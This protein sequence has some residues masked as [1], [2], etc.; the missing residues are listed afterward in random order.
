MQCVSRHSNVFIHKYLLME[1][2]GIITH[3]M[4]HNHGALLQLTGLIRIL[5]SRNVEAKAL[6]FEKSYDF[7]GHDLRAKYEISIRSIG[8]YLKYLRVE[9]LSKTIYNFRKSKTLAK[10]KKNNGLVGEYYTDAHGLDGVIIGSDE[11]FA[12]HTGP[13]PVFFGHAI[14]CNKVFA[15][16][17]SFGPT[18]LAEIERLHCRGFVA[19]GL[20]SLIGI[21]VRDKNSQDVVREL[22]GKDAVMVCDPVLLYGFEK[23]IFT[24]TAPQFDDYLLVYSY[25]NRMNS[26]EEIDA[27]RSYAKANG[28]K[29]LSPGFYH[30]W[31][32]Y[33]IN[34]DP[35]Q[36]LR[37]FKYAKVVVT[38]TFHGSIM[39]MIT[40]A[41]FIVKTRECNHFKLKSLLSEYALA[42][43]IIQDWSQMSQIFETNINYAQV[44]RLIIARRNES[45]SFLDSMLKLS[46]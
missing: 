41:E 18:D 4:V 16:A 26:P 27:I 42:D 1:K 35:I 43:R 23:E 10:Y 9:G 2:Y 31:C 15:Y 30:G 3:Y 33:N 12:L 40:G 38:D 29:T 21:S 24:L 20:E 13:T 7:L 11:V 14:P 32:D 25:D 46:L 44:N 36:I 45:M 37:Y 19:S 6:R 34:A 28:L 17:G 8:S 5:Q 39:S 22:I